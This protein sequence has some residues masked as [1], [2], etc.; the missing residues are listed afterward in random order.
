[1][2]RIIVPGPVGELDGVPVVGQVGPQGNARE[3]GEEKEEAEGKPVLKR[4]GSGGRAGWGGIHG[5]KP[6]AGERSARDKGKKL[7]RTRYR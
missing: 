7:R 5:R 2:Q 6:E 4:G 3:N 1:M